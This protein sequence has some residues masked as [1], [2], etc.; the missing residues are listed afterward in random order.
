MPGPIPNVNVSSSFVGAG[1][2]AGLFPE[3][4]PPPTPSPGPEGTNPAAERSVSPAGQAVGIVTSAPAT[5]ALGLIALVV[6]FLLVI[7]RLP[8]RRRKKDV[9]G[10][11]P[12]VTPVPTPSPGPEG[13][14]PAAERSVSPAGQAAD[15]F[16]ST[17][18]TPA[19]GLI[20]LVVAFLLVMARLF[21]RRRTNRRPGANR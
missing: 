10:L 4:T 6:A 11:F 9:A 15:V 1:N 16:T 14:N 8:A 3:I 5:S 20:A 7:T 19:L 18:A 17:S 12:E 2:A 13:T 21:V